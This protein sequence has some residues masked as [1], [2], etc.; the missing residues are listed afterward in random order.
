MENESIYCINCKCS[1]NLK[2]VAFRTLGKLLIGWAFV[3]P[4]CIVHIAHKQLQLT[5]SSN[6]PEDLTLG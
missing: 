6:D 4:N 2:M 5:N 3:C 1:G